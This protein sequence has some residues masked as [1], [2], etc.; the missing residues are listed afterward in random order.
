[1]AYGTLKCDNIVFDNGGTDKL[2]TVSGLFFSTSGALTVT[3]T[4]SGGNVTAPTATFTTLTGTTTAGTTATFTSGSFTTLTGTTVTGTTAN[5][6]SGVFT[7]QISGASI[8]GTTVAATTGNYTSL[9][10]VTT[11]GTTANFVTFNGAS[12]VFTTR[13]S[14]AT[15][16][17]TTAN[18]TSGNFISLSGTTTTVTSG[19]FSAGSAT[20]PSVAVGTGTSNAPGIYSPGTDQLAISTNGTGRVFVNAAGLVDISNTTSDKLTL[21]YPGFGIGT[22]GV[23]STGSLLFK[24]DEANTQASSIIQ[25]KIDGGEKLRI[26]SSGNLG[27]GVVPSSQYSTIKALQFGALGGTTLGGNTSAGGTSFFGQNF[28]SDPSTAVLK[29]A[30]SSYAATNYTQYA[31][32]HRWY[33]AP[34]GTAGNAIT[35]TQAMTLDASGRLGIGTSAPSSWTNASPALVVVNSN[36]TAY[37]ATLF[38]ASPNLILAGGSASGA[39]NAIRFT[40]AGANEASF[41]VVQEAGGAGAFVFQGYS[42]TAYSERLRIDSS[43]RVGIGTTSPGAILHTAS[44]SDGYKLL[45]DDTTNNRTLGIYSDSTIG[46]LIAVN[47]ARSSWTPIG[48]DGSNVQFLING[49][50]KARID[51]SGRLLVGTVTGNANGGVLQ[52]SSGITFPATAA[53]ASDANTLDDYE[54]GT[55][56]PTQGAGLTVVGTFSSGG[57]Y[58]KVG[59]QVT[60]QGYVAGSTSV[61]AA[62]SSILCGGLPFVAKTAALAQCVGSAANAN[63]NALI[64]VL[65]NQ[66][67]SDVYAVTTMAATSTIFFTVSYLT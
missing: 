13:V 57:H 46:K 20:A 11:T 51:S 48:I 1:M 31:G 22:F 5:F 25:F 47:N 16:T 17:G 27:L 3:G 39:Y 7:T 52:L 36:T 61:A 32:E 60:V 44:T 10:G 19:V 56:T 23:D 33:N 30:A 63:T 53:A 14:G 40:G 45:A 8:T 21:S 55:W 62:T 9:T 42:G 12:G 59:R 28:Y 6:V 43:G 41:G 49:I 65:V 35:F 18:F 2:V 67:T 34:S 64:N 4:I 15:I 58:T 38:A 50:E 37:S 26:D 66:G 24:A 29:Y 54:E